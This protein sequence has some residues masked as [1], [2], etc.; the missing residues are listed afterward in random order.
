MEQDVRVW[1]GRLRLMEQLHP[2]FLGRVARFPM[3]A[4]DARAG[5]VLPDVGPASVSGHH[6]VNGEVLGLL[7]TVLADVAVPDE[8]LLP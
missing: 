1:L 7:A 6:M 3:V 2:G 4:R 8:H 5:N